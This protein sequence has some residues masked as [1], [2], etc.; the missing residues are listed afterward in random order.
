M[1]Y[2]L[3]ECLRGT[4]YSWAE[5]FSS[6]WGRWSIQ[7]QAASHL[8]TDRWY[9][10]EE[11]RSF[12]W[13][14]LTLSPSPK[15]SFLSLIIIHPVPGLPPSLRRGSEERCCL[16]ILA[17]EGN[18]MHLKAGRE[19][20]EEERGSWGRVGEEK[21]KSVGGGWDGR[22]LQWLCALKSPA[23]AAENDGTVD[24]STTDH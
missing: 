3:S 22:M 23:D 9:Y 20:E 6:I 7:I 19:E 8:Q 14:I 16:H 17:W 18:A 13:L 1:A 2:L 5:P 21:S 12:C 10:T 24:R 15:C 11:Q 4:A